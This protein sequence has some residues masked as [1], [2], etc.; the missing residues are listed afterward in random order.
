MSADLFDLPSGTAWIS[1]DGLYRYSLTRQ[2]GPGAGV[3]LSL[4]LNPSTAD[5]DA[6]DHTIRKDMGFARRHGCAKLVK[7]NLFAMRSTD[8]R[9]LI[10]APDP[11]G[12]A[13]DDVLA[14][15]LA[16][17]PQYVV[18]AWG[19]WTG[20]VG[21]LVAARVPIVLGMIRKAGLTPMCLGVSADGSPRH[22]LMLAYATPLV[23]LP[24]ESL[25]ARPE[26]KG[27]P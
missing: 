1:D 7:G 22:P 18:C 21:R 26:S 25:P 16:G 8:P 4:S 11:V 2:I 12:P 15:M 6:D 17:K 27:R 19:R 20:A 10:D 5:A 24:D 9:G 3:W 23:P 13:N 14:G